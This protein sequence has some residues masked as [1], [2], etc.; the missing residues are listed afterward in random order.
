MSVRVPI[1]TKGAAEPTSGR[2]R[3]GRQ[4]KQVVAC[5]SF[6]VS[7][8]NIV[9]ALVLFLSVLR[10]RSVWGSDKLTEEADAR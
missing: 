7:N 3:R 2:R 4:P 10:R 1:E 8:I 9:T 5:V 6:C